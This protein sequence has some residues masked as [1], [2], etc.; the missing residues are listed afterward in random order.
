MLT[1]VFAS[2]S[3]LYFPVRLSQVWV[4]GAD[5]GP[6]PADGFRAV[7]R[8]DTGAVL[9]VHRDGYQLLPNRA[10]FE[11]LE[12]ALLDADLPL[13]RVEVVDQLAYGGRWAIRT[14]VLPAITLAPRVG[15]LVRLRLQALNSYGAERAFRARVSGQRLICTNGLVTEAGAVAVYGR[16]TS[17][18]SLRR[19]VE[20]LRHAVEAFVLKEAEWRGWAERE[21]AAAEATEVFQAMPGANAR[22]VARLTEHWNQEAGALGATLWA[23]YNALTHWSSHEPVRPASV[24]NRAA[25]VLGREDRVRQ[26]MERP[27]FQRLTA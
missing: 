9:G 7:V 25:I 6:A 15:D 8:E 19:A 11:G 5:G 24:P 3:D 17:G 12:A 23:L 26:L 20:K 13:D 4:P 22:L 18:F 21:I 27:A 16:H 10:L 2:E 14:Y 1:S